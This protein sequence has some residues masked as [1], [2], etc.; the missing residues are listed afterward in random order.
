MGVNEVDEKL[1]E[2]KDVGVSNDGIERVLQERL[3]PA[4][5][6][7]FH[8]GHDEKRNENGAEQD[9]NSHRDVTESNHDKGCDLGSRESQDRDHIAEDFEG[10][11]RDRKSRVVVMK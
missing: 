2:N 11:D 8:L 9:S 6:E 4:P 1:A 7:P 10:I 5:E 3:K